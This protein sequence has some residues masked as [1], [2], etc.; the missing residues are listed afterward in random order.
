MSQSCK[1]SHKIRRELF[2]NSNAIVI[3]LV[4]MRSSF[5]L[6]N[7][8]YGKSP[9]VFSQP[10]SPILCKCS[11]SLSLFRS[12]RWKSSTVA[13]CTGQHCWVG[14]Q[15]EK[16]RAID[17]SCHFGS[18]SSCRASRAFSFK[19]CEQFFVQVY[20]IN[21]VWLFGCLLVVPLLP[22]GSENII[23][24]NVCECAFSRFCRIDSRFK[25]TTKK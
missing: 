11:L 18:V 16:K 3:R 5:L 8:H 23:T 7:K 20:F 10:N 2:M 14:I 12:L 4:F 1:I 9:S 24:F 19:I 21:V 6:F 25:R 13:K 15:E 22:A 17:F